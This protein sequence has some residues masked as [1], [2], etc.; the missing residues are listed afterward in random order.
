MAE[1][2]KQSFI[3]D[4]TDKIRK[5]CG[6]EESKLIDMIDVV[7]K[8]GFELERFEDEPRI[9]GK[10][11]NGAGIKKIYV[12]KNSGRPERFTI[13]HEIGHIVL[14]HQQYS[15][16]ELKI[17][18]RTEDNQYNQKEFQANMFA[19][20]FLMPESEVRKVWNLVK[21]IDIVSE[22]FEVSKRSAE[23]RLSILKLI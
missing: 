12:N 16:A 23:I 7:S 14:H 9:N 15:G 17:D 11:H 8:I 21:D 1:Y 10:V 18:Y 20:A 13:A 19:S 5:A 4:I 22:L 2:F 6:Y 3:E